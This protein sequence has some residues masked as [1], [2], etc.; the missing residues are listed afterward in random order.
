MEKIAFVF[1]YH[2]QNFY[3]L[4][5]IAGALETDRVFESID[6]YFSRS[7][8]ELINVLE[9]KVKSYRKIV[10]AISFFTSQLFDTHA[11]LKILKLRIQKNC[12][13][14][15]G[16]S[17][18]TGDPSGTLKMGFD[19]V[20]VG[21]GEETIIE[22]MQKI[23]A[24][25]S[26]T[27]V[28][29]I[30]FNSDN[31]YVYTGKRAEIN[32]DKYPPFP[33]KNTRYGA[34]EITRGCPYVCYFCQTPYI[35]GTTPRHRSIE[36]IS[37]YVK[38]LNNH[39]GDLT[40]IR[41]I[42]PNA[43]SY[44]SVDGKVINLEKLEALVSTVRE[45]IG[46][47]GRIFFGTFPSEVRPEHVTQETLDLVLKFANN[48]NI[49]IGAQSGSQKVLDLCHRGHS[50]EEIYRAVE[51]TIKNNLEINVDFIFGLP[52]EKTEDINLTIK[53]MKELAAKGARIHAH[54]FIPLPQTPFS[55]KPVTKISGIYKKEIQNLISQGLAFGSWR[56]QEILASKIAEYL[57]NKELI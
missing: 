16:G 8:D 42:S 13:L 19:I 6:F 3:S 25:K 31:Q 52:G 38:E 9:E 33:I 5:A 20:V 1:Y 14:I 49:T 50:V 18:P 12:I 10:V 41:F 22:L 56:N 26:L 37:I 44:G 30:A 32:L 46:K 47:K 48:D 55:K 23:N 43:F 29:G 45:I 11:L 34:I 17:H 39:Y 21:E 2:K 53:M 36:N 57:K 15:A 35:L 4:N 7:I 24:N 51:L 40:D 54:A 27:E 28:K